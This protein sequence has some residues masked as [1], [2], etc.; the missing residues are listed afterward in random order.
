MLS[1]DVRVMFEI[2]TLKIQLFFSYLHFNKRS[3][4]F[5]FTFG[6]LYVKKGKEDEEGV[7]FSL[8]V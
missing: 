5:G 2:V 4:I 3:F 1:V 8:L 6:E 7:S